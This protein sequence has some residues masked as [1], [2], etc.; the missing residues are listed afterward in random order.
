MNQKWTIKNRILDL[1]KK[2]LSFGFTVF[3]IVSWLTH[4]WIMKHGFDRWVY[5]AYLLF[6]AY[7]LTRNSFK[8][9]IKIYFNKHDK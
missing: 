7:M 6:V 9:I 8:D 4:Y 1:I 3:I 5:G 2:C